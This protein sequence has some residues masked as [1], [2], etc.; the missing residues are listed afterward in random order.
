MIRPAILLIT[1]AIVLASC[2]LPNGEMLILATPT[3][4]SVTGPG[5]SFPIGYEISA[6]IQ[7]VFVADKVLSEAPGLIGQ[8][9]EYSEEWPMG[10]FL[11]VELEIVNSSTSGVSASA[12]AVLWSLT[13]QLGFVYRG[14]QYRCDRSIPPG[15]SSR[16]WVCFDIHKDTRSD[17][18]FYLLVSDRLHPDRKIPLGPLPRKEVFI[19]P[20]KTP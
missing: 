20:P 3:P 8:P 17:A 19:L 7:D 16:C 14:P 5:K 15:Q 10:M 1:V 2:T 12:N 4:D 9:P 11:V 6:S 18:Q 13:D